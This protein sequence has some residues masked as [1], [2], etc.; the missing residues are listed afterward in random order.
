MAYLRH[1]ATSLFRWQV[2][3][4]DKPAREPERAFSTP[5]EMRGFFASLTPEQ[6][7][8]ALAHRG[9]DELRDPEYNA[10]SSPAR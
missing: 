9:N 1:L 8:R 2:T 5:R 10:K 3:V 4:R 6:K 7:A